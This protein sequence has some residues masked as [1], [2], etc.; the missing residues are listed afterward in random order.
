MLSALF[1]AGP[2]ANVVVMIESTA[3]AVNAA[4]APLMNLVAIRVVPSLARP[5]I[6]EATRKTASPP[7]RTRRRPSRSAAR[8]PRSSS[9]P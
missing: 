6:K 2:S 1:R 9:P 4:A 7:S 8:P 5:P 3:G